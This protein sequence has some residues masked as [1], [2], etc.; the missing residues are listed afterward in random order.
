MIYQ[1]KKKETIPLIISSYYINFRQ[2]C[3]PH[4]PRI[5]TSFKE[6]AKGRRKR[7]LLPY[8]NFQ[9]FPTDPRNFAVEKLGEKLGDSRATVFSSGK[10]ANEDILQLPP[11]PFRFLDPPPRL[12]FRFSLPSRF[13]SL[14]NYPP[15]PPRSDGSPQVSSV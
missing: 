11:P 8:K 6:A 9:L 13:R 15:P 4:I 12:P 1:K 3:Q 7:S 14:K 2:R 10:E 5:R